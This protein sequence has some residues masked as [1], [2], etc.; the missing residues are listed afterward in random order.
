MSR[1]GW[2]GRLLMLGA[3][4][5]AFGAAV[6][7]GYAQIT[8]AITSDGT[9]GTTVNRSGNVIDING[10][11][12]KG[13]NQFHSFRQFNVGTG[14]IASFNGPPNVTIRNILSRVTGGTRSEIDGTLRSTIPGANLFL[15]NPSGI[16]FG[17]NA[18]LD[19]SG[20]FHATT[21]DYIRLQDGARFNAV[22]S[23]ADNLLTTAPPAAFGFLTTNPA[24]IDVQAGVV[25]LNVFA[26]TN[27]L[28]VPVG[29]TL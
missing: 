4:L 1:S 28:Q 14:D 15:M 5:C 27:V 24:P 23:A 10:G 17:P 2:H 22:P 3:W 11:T 29:Q 25:D 9:L 8:T 21:A 12:I 18:R 26:F 7:H 6:P 16:L 19:V 20:S 13:S